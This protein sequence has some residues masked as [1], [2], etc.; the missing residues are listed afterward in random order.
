MRIEVGSVDLPDFTTYIIKNAELLAGDTPE[1]PSVERISIMEHIRTR[2][3]CLFILMLFCISAV[4]AQDTAKEKPKQEEKKWLRI[5]GHSPKS[6]TGEFDEQEVM[7]VFNEDIALKD[8]NAEWLTVNRGECHRKEIGQNYVR[9]ILPKYNGAKVYSFSISENLIGKTSGLPLA[10]DKRDLSFGSLRVTNL[11][12][13]K[14]NH[15]FFYLYFNINVTLNE[16]QDNLIVTDE[17][18]EPVGFRMVD[19]EANRPNTVIVELLRTDMRSVRFELPAM[20]KD[21]SGQHSLDS[22]WVRTL[23]LLKGGKSVTI[24]QL[25][26]RSLSWESIKEQHQTVRL[27]FNYSIRGEELEKHLTVY[28]D[29]QQISYKMLGDY[30]S[31]HIILVNLPDY[32]KKGL[33]AKVTKGLKGSSASILQADQH[34]SLNANIPTINFYNAEIYTG[35]NGDRS[36]YLS[37]RSAN[38]SLESIQEHLEVDPRPENLRIERDKYS[39]GYRVF[40]DWVPDKEYQVIVRK[41]LLVNNWYPMKKDYRFTVKGSKIRPT[42]NIH[43]AEKFY[44]ARGGRP[45]VTIDATGLKSAKVSISRMFPEN[46]VRAVRHIDRNYNTPQHSFMSL[47]AEPLSNK[48]LDLNYH[49]YK[50]TSTLLYLDDVL[51]EEQRGLFSLTAS[52]RSAGTRSRLVL[53]TDLGTMA[54]W[55]GKSLHMFVHDL[56]TLQPVKSASVTVYSVK[57]QKLATAFTNGEGMVS[58]EGFPGALGSP[59]VAVVEKGN[60]YT[61]LELRPLDEPNE[62]DNGRDEYNPAKYE[63]FIYFDRDLY[64]PGEMV[65]LRFIGRKNV[66]RD[67]LADIPLQ[68]VILKPNGKQM[69]SST[70]KF[71]EFGTASFDLKTDKDYATGKYTAQIKTPG[72]KGAIASGVFQLET[73][74]PARMRATAEISEK[75]WMTEKEYAISVK[76]EQ[77]HGGPAPERKVDCV[78]V[79]E[80]VKSIPGFEDYRFTNESG[81]V[82]APLNLGETR[83][84][85]EGT[86][87]FPAQVQQF[88][89]VSTPL[90]A[91]AVTRAYE[92]GGRRVSSAAE[93]LY[94]SDD[95][96]LGMNL[97]EGENASSVMADVVAV[98]TDDMSAATTQTVSVTLERMS[99]RY[100]M[101]RYYGYYGSSWRRDYEP[102]ETRKIQLKDGKAQVIF[103]RIHYG[104]YRVRVTSDETRMACEQTFRKDWRDTGLELVETHSKDVVR[105]SLDKAVYEP[106][107]KARLTIQSPFDGRAII[108]LQD[109]DIKRMF[110]AEITDGKC[111]VIIPVTEEDQPNIWAEVTVV[112]TP[113]KDAFDGFPYA[114]FNVQ[115]IR[116]RPAETVLNVSVDDL[117]EKI[118]PE[119]KLKLQLTTKDG[120][121]K[122]V[123]AECTVA[124]VDEGIHLLSNYKKPEP[125]DYIF[126]SRNP[127]RLY[128]AHYYDLVQYD[129]T[130]PASGGDSPSSIENLNPDEMKKRLGAERDSWIK[131]VALW[132]GAVMTDENGKAEIEVDVPEFTG[133]L[134]VVAVAVSKKSAAST[135]DNIYVKRPFML[136]TSMPRYLLTG[137]EA[138]C[139]ATVFNTTESDCKAKISWEAD[140]KF[141]KGDGSRKVEIKAGGEVSVPARVI[142]RDVP[143]SGSMQWKV[144]IEPGDDSPERTLSETAALPVNSPSHLF[145]SH[146][147]MLKLMPGEK[148][149]LENTVFRDDERVEASMTI[150]TNPML[151]LERALK[152]V[153]GYPYGCVEQTTSRCFP[154][155]VLRQSKDFLGTSLEKDNRVDFM[156]QAGIDRLFNMQTRDGGLGYW[157]GYDKPYPF[158]SV[159]AAH[160]LAHAWK[161]REFDIDEDKYNALMHYVRGVA[162]NSSSHKAGWLFLRAYATYVLAL[163]GD[164]DAPGLIEGFDK[165]DAMPVSGRYL[166][167][168][169]VA[170]TTRDN[171]KVKAYMQKYPG[172]KWPE[173]QAGGTLNSRLREKSL[174]LIALNAANAPQEELH[175]LAIEM[176][177]ALENEKANRWRLTT[178]ESAFMLI[179]LGEYMTEYT[180]ARQNEGLGINIKWND[181]EEKLIGADIFKGE[182][183]GKNTRFVVENNGTGIAIINWALKGVPEELPLEPIS[184]G[185]V[186]KRSFLDKDGK[187]IDGQ[188]FRQTDNVVVCLEITASDTAENVIVA[189]MLPAGLEI[190]NPRLADGNL[191]RM[192]L[193]SVKPGYMDLR[194]DRLI[195][196]FGSLAKNK[197]YRYYYVATPVTP[198]KFVYPPV[199]AECMYA[200]DVRA[201]SAPAEIEVKE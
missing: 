76:A 7:L 175:A 79:F 3:T 172:M 19:A 11:S 61:F 16:V 62:N 42:L 98:K 138:V 35:Y 177:E 13:G 25:T 165:V 30:G 113:T 130:A 135:E 53:V 145:Q 82:P 59:A 105:T 96:L 21:A 184:E 99:W 143:A 60:D 141:I 196:F 154:M 131:S 200:P 122:A 176:M 185:L 39:N 150:S 101:R 55:D 84:D 15:S 123:A 66:G 173:V 73:Y 92:L 74:V 157:P 117:P 195:L 170:L 78:L 115:D 71:S 151:R 128:R 40:A 158:G 152:F 67:P 9:M 132:S 58:F 179:A 162:K 22:H 72:Q 178:H 129:F 75:V 49:A 192:G 77:L 140:G 147:E 6:R 1:L 5:T 183:K 64:R 118:E 174:R 97:K 126:R 37:L 24:N 161:S 106:G 36:F 50:S 201:H 121:D 20:T 160:F 187:E 148:M 23:Q 194:D 83:T 180:K 182:R 46:V 86:A 181:G 149:A 136:R 168:A 10:P 89:G 95:L 186:V 155:F 26:L 8:E 47:C 197:T 87:R 48:T 164:P 116:V 166:L 31:Y 54:Q 163:N 159:Y 41:G 190:E 146:T 63:C 100:Y 171:E 14:E 69:E 189:D 108:V 198:G 124:L 12:R 57:Q 85:A 29:G 193:E 80:K 111:E 2:S 88:R 125:A 43:E 91:I 81:K 94:L 144:E 102:I 199:Q 127:H 17:K 110:T 139:R 103:Q 52:D 18:H 4:F 56:R 188:T 142:A 90:K 33:T 114:A 44:F 38:M 191:L 107:D 109:Y 137:D 134:R 156:V 153:V 133:Q 93:A 169:A 119:T 65:H 45:H 167:A 104:G 27:S 120:L 32:G 51:P 68:L 28:S 70:I 34:K 112:H